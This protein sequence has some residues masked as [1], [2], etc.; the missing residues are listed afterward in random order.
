MIL[1]LELMSFPEANSGVAENERASK[2]TL[3]VGTQVTPIEKASKDFK[4]SNTWVQKKQGQLRARLSLRNCELSQASPSCWYEQAMHH[5]FTSPNQDDLQ[6]GHAIKDSRA[7]AYD[8]VY[9]GSEIGGESTN[10]N[11]LICVQI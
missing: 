3:Q 6:Q 7:L 9:N 1:T 4:L 2:T 10:R 8:M 11:A 5:P